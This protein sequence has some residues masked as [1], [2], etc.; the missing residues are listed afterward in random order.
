MDMAEASAGGGGG[1]GDFSDIFGDLFGR[2]GQGGAF[3]MRG[4]D[5]RYNLEISFLEAVNG[6]KKR[7]QFPDNETLDITVPAGVETGQT[8]RLR[9]KGGPG[10]GRGEPGDALIELKVQ[11]HPLFSRDG[12]NITMEL[13]IALNEAVLGARVEVPTIGGRVT[14]AVPKGA[15]SGQVLRLRGK[16]VKN[17]RSGAHGDQMITL[18][19][20]L[21]SV[22]DSDLERLMQD[23][24]K[25]RPYDPARAVPGSRWRRRLT[26]LPRGGERLRLARLAGPCRRSHDFHDK[27]SRQQRHESRQRPDSIPAEIR[28]RE[29]HIAVIAAED[30]AG[31]GRV[32]R[33]VQF[34]AGP[35]RNQ[36]GRQQAQRAGQGTRAGQGR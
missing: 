26:Q 20:V 21:P 12:D 1:G 6:V 32:G 2:K 16:G 19:I 24:A 28:E 34:A 15:S 7:V 3:T 30:R 22:I 23:W 4:M 14:V 13:P 5:Y 11:P 31:Q 35:P 17:N 18:K 29:K 36:P 10:A 27:P 25:K 9:H 33:E 8:L